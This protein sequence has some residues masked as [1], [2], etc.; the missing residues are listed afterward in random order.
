MPHLDADVLGRLLAGPAGP[1]TTAVRLF[2]DAL[3]ADLDSAADTPDAAA[4]PA[5][6]SPSA[7]EPASSA[8]VVVPELY[9]PRAVRDDPVLGHVVNERLVAWAEEMGLF[10]GRLERLRKHDFG[11]LFMLAHPDTDDPDRL[12][13]AARCGLAEWAVDDHW[14][15]EGDDTRPELIG[16]R[17]ALAHAV[18]DPIRLPLRYEPEFEKV[19]ASEPVLRAFRSA[20]ALLGTIANPTQVARLRHELAVMFVGY[21]QEA[22]WRMSGRRPAVWEY[23]M[24][25]YENAFFP[26]MVLV[27]P[28]GGYELPAHEFADHRVRRTYLYAGVANVLLNDLYSMGKEDPTDT[29][30]PNLIAAEEGC[31][32]QEAVDKAA[33]VHDELMHLVEAESAALS[34]LGSPELK[35]FL[36]GVW[37]WMGGSHTWHATSAR[38]NGGS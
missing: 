1:G 7:A 10:Q 17:V 32:L 14:V 35:R 27:D 26:C 13:A 12:L 8:S 4:A 3:A 16:L 30:L 38:Y 20:L 36:A 28:V 21:G 6:A 11:R 19:V 2:R 25:R 34:A 9:C 23:L 5:P 18:V 24:H 37:A 33:A 15:D 22:E 29:N 31:T